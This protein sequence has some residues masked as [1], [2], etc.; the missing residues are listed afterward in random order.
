MD[1]THINFPLPD[2][3]R[4]PI[5]N[6]FFVAVWHYIANHNM[7]GFATFCRLYGLQQGNLYRLAQNPTRQFNPNLLTLMVK[8]G[9]SANW[10]LTGHGSMLRKYEA[11]N[12]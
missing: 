11:K 5:Q 6:R 3:E 1:K 2:A 12:A 10:L 7:R 9:Y 8:L 4:F